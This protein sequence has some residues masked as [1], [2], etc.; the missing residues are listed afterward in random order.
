MNA[1][2]DQ[3]YSCSECG[4]SFTQIGNLK[5]HRRLHTGEKPFSCSLCS[6]SFRQKGQLDSHYRI[7]TGE[8]PFQ[9]Y[10]CNLKFRQ[11]NNLN[12]HMQ[13]NHEQVIINDEGV[14]SKPKKHNERKNFSNSNTI[15]K[16]MLMQTK[17]DDNSSDKVK[18]EVC[19]KVLKTKLS[20]QIHM[21]IHTGETPFSCKLCSKAFRQISNFNLHMQM[22][23]DVIIPSK[24]K[25][26]K[27][28]KLNI[29][30]ENLK[31]RCNVL[32][33]S[34]EEKESIHTP[35]PDISM[36]DDFT[37]FD[38]DRVS[39]KENSDSSLIDDQ[40]YATENNPKE[41]EC[42]EEVTIKNENLQKEEEKEKEPLT[43]QNDKFVDLIEKLRK[44]YIDSKSKL[45]ALELEITEV[46]EDNKSKQIVITKLNSVVEKKT[47]KEKELIANIEAKEN[48]I[49]E[50]KMQYM[51]DKTNLLAKNREVKRL[52]DD[53]EQELTKMKEQFAKIEIIKDKR[54][55]PVIDGA[56]KIIKKYNAERC[57]KSCQ[58]DK[59]ECDQCLQY[60]DSFL[61]TLD[62]EGF[63]NKMSEKL[64]ETDN[65]QAKCIVLDLLATLVNYHPKM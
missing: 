4:K 34:S 24:K 45:K 46:K 1:N 13:N 2:V 60:F 16:G 50:I 37:S 30:Y 8:K 63:L 51:R 47:Y 54:R 40:S 20:L 56:S 64:I 10:V 53:K 11:K 23:H 48:A 28:S 52:L 33:K 15:R 3:P 39:K 25:I 27:M 12:Y 5:V 26:K 49:N 41:V 57:C 65:Q 9:C 14:N 29:D 19:N 59:V 61:L 43:E 38:S 55:G 22:N 44:D 17:E 7:H 31:S 6:W 35:D 42:F 21:R 36:K 32:S 58:N 18:C 62:K